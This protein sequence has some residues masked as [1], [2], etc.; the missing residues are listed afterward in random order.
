M[1]IG[2]LARRTGLAARTLRFYAD[3]GVLPE[4]SS[5]E[6]GY[7]L[8][9]TEAVAR[10]RL[11]RTLRE[12]GIGLEDIK[13]VLAAEVSLALPAGGSGVVGGVEP[14]VAAP[15]VGGGLRR[16]TG[17]SSW[18]ASPARQQTAQRRQ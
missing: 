4:T 3:A 13:R 11:L 6:S 8:F 14:S 15:A 18:V 12:L 7:R 10:A 1:T 17:N 9:G 2:E 5:S 16:D